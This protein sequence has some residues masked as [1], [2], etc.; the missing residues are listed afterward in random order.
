LRSYSKDSGLASSIAAIYSAH[1]AVSF[2]PAEL[3]V[4]RVL[5]MIRSLQVRQHPKP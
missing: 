2:Q 4:S 3:Q 1:E 5:A